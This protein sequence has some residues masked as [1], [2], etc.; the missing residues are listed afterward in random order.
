MQ[1]LEKIL[2]G[3]LA[4]IEEA[5]LLRQLRRI[6]SVKGCRLLHDGRWLTQFASN[7]YLG[8]ASHPDVIGAAGDALARFGAGSG[9]SRLVCGSLGVHHELEESIA[10][11]KSTQAALSFSSGFAAALGVIPAFLEKGD[12]IIID[13]LVHA[14]CVDAARLS[15]ATL[16][17]CRHNDLNHLA[18]LLDWADAQPDPMGRAKRVLIV[19]ESVFS[20][21][22]DLAPLKELTELK[23]RHG[24]WLMLDEAHAT[25]V[26]GKKHSGLAEALGVADRV[27]IQMGTLSKGLGSAGGFIAG[28][29][30]LVDFL[31][32]SARSFVFSTA[33]APAAAGAAVAAIRLVR[34]PA[35]EEIVERLWRNIAELGRIVAAQPGGPTSAVSPIVPWIIGAE[36][37]A[38]QA[39]SQLRDLGIFA[40]AIRYPTVP[41]GRA[42]LRFSVSAR[43]EP[44]DFQALETA[45]KQLPTAPAPSL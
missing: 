21:D 26:F 32:N 3:E 38:V 40:P 45:L 4:G 18:E 27:E 16:R 12:I 34:S 25:G 41:R 24:A 15:G 10:S 6:D 20:M 43:H 33:P 1:S 8:F 22:G 29:R 2:A 28:S 30:E 31:I 37:A 14:C 36:S 39:A 35:G 13:K 19:T 7:D 23:D 11:W 9:A 5:G 44:A 17:V 42:R